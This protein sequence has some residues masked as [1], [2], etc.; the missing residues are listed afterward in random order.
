MSEVVFAFLD[1]TKYILLGC[2]PDLG[3][4]FYVNAFYRASDR[5][6]GRLTGFQGR[7]KVNCAG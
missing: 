6:S 1:L 4:H 3:R 2:A 7:G 5:S